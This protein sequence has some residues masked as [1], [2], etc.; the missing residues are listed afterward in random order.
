MTA[1]PATSLK[2]KLPTEDGSPSDKARTVMLVG[3]QEQANLGLGYLAAVLRRHGYRVTIFDVEAGSDTILAAALQLKPILIGFSLIFQF[4]VERFGALI[5]H[6]RREGVDCHFT[7]GGHFPSLSYQ[8]ALDLIPE[9]DSVARFEGE[10]TLLELA[11]CLAAGR[12]WRNVQGLAYVAAN[13]VMTTAPRHLIEDLD[14]LPYP[15]RATKRKNTIL[16]RVATSLIASRGCARSCSFCSIHMFYRAAP[17][18]VVRTRKPAHVVEEMRMLYEEQGV[19]IFLFQDDDFPLFGPVW[20][21]WSDDLLDQLHRS[22]LANKVIWKIN[23]RADV[24]EAQRFLAMRE[25]G[26]YLVYM[27]L[28]SGTDEGL[29]TLHKKVT[30]EQNISAVDT[31]KSIDVQFEYGFML[32]DPSTTFES[33]RANIAF[34]RRIVGDGS[35]AATFCRMIPYDGTPIKDELAREGRLRGD[36][37]N[38]DYDFLDGRLSNYYYAL[39]QMINS[40]GWIQGGHALSPQLN[41][42]WHETA[43]MERL[44][45]PLPDMT[46][47]KKTLARVT[48]ES[49][50]LL[51]RLA[52]DLSYVYSDGAPD[53]WST[54]TLR[55]QCDRLREELVDERDCFVASHQ[56]VL[57]KALDETAMVG[58][59]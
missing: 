46:A 59:A 6:L 26:L 20:R 29:G 19:T 50:A 55:E 49:N 1:N 31:L 15:E 2:D 36:V 42:A 45:P 43:V 35:V 11:E 13:E 54:A 14:Q 24:V 32:F 22:G 41:W 48:R 57:L 3:F 27:G 38:P 40:A 25:A 21:R 23:C 7:I 9:L 53:V 12:D 16:G 5:R 33:V 52:E 39:T 47:Y 58:V 17:G 10:L 8:H 44:F 56:A 4:Y 34:L 18:K 37:C 30:V 51:L 28:E